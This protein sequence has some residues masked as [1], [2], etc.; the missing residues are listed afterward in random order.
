MFIAAS[1]SGI[2][3]TMT[4]DGKEIDV[5]ASGQGSVEFTAISST[6]DKEGLARKTYEAA[7]SVTLPGGK[8]TTF[9]SEIEYFVVK[10]TIQIQS[11]AVQALY[12]RCGNNLDVQV[13]QLGVAY[14]PS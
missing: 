13:P 6:F 12:L 7:I 14:N 4:Y 8:D 2:T 10:P 9:T 3:P 11:T 1:S 5:D